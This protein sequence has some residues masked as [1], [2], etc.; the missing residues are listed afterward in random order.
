MYPL[1]FRPELASKCNDDGLHPR[2]LGVVLMSRMVRMCLLL[3]Y[4]LLLLPASAR[5]DLVITEFFAATA[6]EN[7][8]VELF[9]TGPST[10]QM[11]NAVFA[12]ENGVQ[13]AANVGSF[14]IAPGEFAVLFNADESNVATQN[15]NWQNDG[16]RV[17]FINWIEVSNWTELEIGDRIAIWDSV[18]S[19]DDGD[20]AAA[21]DEVNYSTSVPW[22]SSNFGF[23]QRVINPM[24]DNNVGSNWVTSSGGV[25]AW[26]ASNIF[27]RGSPGHGYAVPEPNAMVLLGVAACGV[28]A[29][30][31]IRRRKASGKTEAD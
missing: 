15:A 9:N 30:G 23:S 21:I 14:A 8:Y 6:V 13:P 11:D 1:S 5:A 17:D 12:T 29:W 18:A 28:A 4:L 10:I 2:E 24:A 19:Y 26:P 16:A 3:M 22:P 27:G 31:S 25:G 7:Q 20:F